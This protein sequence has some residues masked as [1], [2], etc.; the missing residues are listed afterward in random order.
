MW[1]KEFD[2]KDKTSP[3]WYNP[4]EDCS[5]SRQKIKSEDIPQYAENDS[6]IPQ[7]LKA[8]FPG[9]I[10]LILYAAVLFGITVVMFNRYDVR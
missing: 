1:F 4:Y 3:H 9:A 5:T 10:A 7:R 2:L 6:T 8:A